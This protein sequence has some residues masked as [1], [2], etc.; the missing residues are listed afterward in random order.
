MSKAFASGKYAL[1]SCDRCGFTY[2]LN[3]LRDEVVNRVRTGLA[4][5]P[6]C[7][8]EDHPQYRLGEVDATDAEALEN[9]SPDSGKDESR[10]LTG[11][12]FPADIF[13]DS[14]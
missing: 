9:P 8:D 13:Q 2:M 11:T 12:P 1:G 5:C 7:F 3:E 6:D 10:E 4:I 14:P